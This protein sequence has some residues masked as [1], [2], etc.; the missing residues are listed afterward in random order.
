MPPR[1]ML[2]VGLK[3]AAKFEQLMARLINKAG[4]QSMTHTAYH[5]ATIHATKSIAF[6]VTKDFFLL[7][8]STA[9]LHRALDAY[10]TGNSL[11]A[12]TEFRATMSSARATTL[13]LY[14][15]SAVTTKLFDSLQTEAAKASGSVKELA[16]PPARIAGLGLSV[17]PD[18]DGTVVE[19]RAPARLAFAAMAALATSKPASRTTAPAG[20]GIPAPATAPR[21]ASSSRVPKMTDDDMLT[22]RP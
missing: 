11:A 1:F 5:G 10:I 21:P 8:G 22:R 17:L 20:F 12:S 16:Q 13:Q 6:A 19:M 14:L 18:A 9:D 7:S 2:M 3:N 4:A 15:S